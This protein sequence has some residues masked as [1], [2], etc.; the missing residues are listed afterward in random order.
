MFSGTILVSVKS[1]M[2]VS[3]WILIKTNQRSRVMVYLN[4]GTGKLD[5]SMATALKRA[6]ILISQMYLANLLVYFCHHYCS[7]P[8]DPK[9]GCNMGAWYG[10]TSISM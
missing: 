5:F 7:D 8:Q 9:C 10:A 2:M 3:L 4:S 6:C 1:M